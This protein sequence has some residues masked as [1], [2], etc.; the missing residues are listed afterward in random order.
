VKILKSSSHL[1]S[2]NAHGGQQE[3]GGCQCNNLTVDDQLAGDRSEH[4]LTE[5]HEQYLGRHGD[6][7]NHQ[8]P[9]SQV[10]QKHADALVTQLGPASYDHYE[11]YVA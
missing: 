7:T 4:P 1:V 11:R 10:E 2:V 6:E 3:G 9:N 5:R 8:V